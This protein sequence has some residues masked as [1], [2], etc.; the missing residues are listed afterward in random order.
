MSEQFFLT[1][2]AA[3][4]LAE[5]WEYL[6]REAG[7]G[8]ADRYL[9]RIHAACE[10]LVVMPGMGHYREELLDRRHRFWLVGSHLLVYRWQER[11]IQ[12]I[13]VVH[14]ARDLA[15]FLSERRPL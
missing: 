6:A 5:M 3:E 8:A 11:P 7:D 12:I 4:D 15:S 14:G 10:D 9:A 13:R 1:E 2:A